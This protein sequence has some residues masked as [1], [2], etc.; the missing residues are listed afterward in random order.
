MLASFT[1]LESCYKDNNNYVVDD[2]NQA[3][4]SIAADSYAVMRLS[5]LSIVPDI[6][7]SIHDNDSYTYEWKVFEPKERDDY[8]G[9]VSYSE[10]LA[11]A[12]DLKEIIYTP[13]GKYMLLYTVTNN[14]TGVKSFKT[15]SLIVNSGFYEGLVVGYQ[16]DNHAELGFI[17]TD[18]VISY[19]LIQT[20][21]GE[22]LEGTLQEMNTLIV[23]SLRRMA[24][25]TSSNHYHIDMDGFKIMQD[26]TS[27]F[28]TSPMD[29]GRSF[30]GGN[31]MGRPYHAPS[32]IFYINSGRLYADTGPDFVGSIGGMY[33]QAFYYSAGDYELYP[34]LFNGRSAS[35]I[36]FYDNLNGK[37][38]QSG[39]NK[40]T[41]TDVPFHATDKFDP[42]NVKKNAIAAMLGYNNNVYYVMQDGS[43]YYIYTMIQ[44]NSYMAGDI[45]SV[46]LSNAPE[47][48]QARIFDAR[49]DQRYIYYAVKNKLY[50][51]NLV[52]NSARLVL[53]LS[54]SEEIADIHV[55]RS[56]MWQNTSEDDFNKRIYIAS[57]RGESGKVYQ[58][59]TLEDG[60]LL[61]R[62]E[63]EFEGFGKIAD[64]DYRNVNE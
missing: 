39:F 33:S 19:D 2:I 35:I 55:Y 62:A 16:K 18:G 26:K 54:A 20:L 46:D 30:F 15:F 6:I 21:N 28:S 64:V 7:S 42:S 57:N 22:A 1:L 58:Y 5:E 40:R 13:P 48:D 56:N 25:T 31:K 47:L 12:K 53:T 34:F 24:V 52:A 32:D 41:L 43:N 27:L 4:I 59:G 50:L 44:Y 61:N 36:Y 11:T 3:N 49:S 63:R 38:L 60:S 51:Y 29:F 37:F 10:I 14:T 9:R 17:R 8:T 45:Q 23:K